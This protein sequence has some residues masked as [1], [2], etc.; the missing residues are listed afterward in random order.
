MLTE[1]DAL[2]CLLAEAEKFCTTLAD[3]R[4]LIGVE[5]LTPLDTFA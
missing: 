4:K 1:V 3:G 5:E 2:I